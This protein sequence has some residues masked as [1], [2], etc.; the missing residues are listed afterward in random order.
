MVPVASYW[1]SNFNGPA[2]RWKIVFLSSNKEK[3][4]EAHSML[5]QPSTNNPKYLDDLKPIVINS[6]EQLKLLNALSIDIEDI[7]FKVSLLLNI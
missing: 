6:T 3:C 7:Y 5:E 2:I 1:I 4:D